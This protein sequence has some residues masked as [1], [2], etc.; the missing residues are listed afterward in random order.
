MRLET[1]LCDAC[2]KALEQVGD[3]RKHV[4][5]GY[6]VDLCSDCSERLLGIFVG[7]GRPVPVLTPM[8]KPFTWPNTS[9]FTPPGEV[10][11]F[12]PQPT[13]TPTPNIWPYGTLICYTDSGN[14]M[15]MSGTVFLGTTCTAGSAASAQ[16]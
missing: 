13:I 3:A 4:V 7:K 14:S 5:D 11:K 10:G 15:K 8:P 6:E 9:P 12:V 2:G 16:H 1:I